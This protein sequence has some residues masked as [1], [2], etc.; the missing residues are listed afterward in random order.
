MEKKLEEV[1]VKSTDHCVKCD[2]E[3]KTKL[4][5]SD[6]MSFL[7][8]SGAFYCENREC[9]SFGVLTLARISRTV[10]TTPK[11]E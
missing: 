6:F 8:S 9:D 5:S 3:L 2:G 10:K 11:A 1:K 7:G 4:L